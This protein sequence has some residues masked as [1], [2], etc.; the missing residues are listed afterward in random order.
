MSAPHTT[1]RVTGRLKL[2]DRRAGPVWYADTRVPGRSPEQTMRRL[3]PAHVGGPRT[4]SRT[5]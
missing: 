1:R 3:A 2:R 5:C 4:P